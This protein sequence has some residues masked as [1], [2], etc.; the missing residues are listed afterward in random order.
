VRFLRAIPGHEGRAI[1]PILFVLP[2]VLFSLPVSA[3]DPEV[4]LNH[5]THQQWTTAEGLPQ[6]SPQ[7]IVQDDSG[8]LW[9]GTQEG[10][11]RFDGVRFRVFNRRSSPALPA[12]N[13]TAL[14]HCAGQGILAGMR[15]GGLLRILPNGR[16][17][18]LSSERDTDTLLVR[19]LLRDSRGRIWIGTRGNGLLC[20]KNVNSGFFEDIPEFSGNRILSLIESSDGSIWVGTEGHGISVISSRGQVRRLENLDST[21][22]NTIWALCEDRE[23]S[24]WAGSFGG[25]LI[26]FSSDGEVTG[27]YRQSDGLSS[28]RVISLGED[29][30]GNLW[31]GTSHGLDRIYKGRITGSSTGS[32]LEG[33]VI[34]SIL[35]DREGNLWLGTQRSGL[36]RLGDSLFSV[37]GRV[38]GHSAPMAR[39]LCESHDHRIWMGS[40]SQGLF[41]LDPEEKGGVFPKPVPGFEQMDIFALY[42]DAFG[43]LWVG[44]YEKGLFRIRGDRIDSWTTQEG[45]PVD[46]IWAMETDGDHGIW[47]GTYGGGLAHFENGVDAV[48]SSDSGLPSNLVRCLHLDA[49]GI[50]WVGLSS[51]GIVTI[52][53][54]SIVRPEGSEKLSGASVLDIHENPDGSLWLA[55]AEA[56]LCHFQSGRLSCLT[57]DN[58]LFDDKIYRILDD[59]EGQLWMSCN[60]GIFRLSEKEAR[61]C[62]SGRQTRVSCTIL[63]RPDGMPTAE[64]NGGSQPCGW[65]DH[66]G[67]LWFPTPE[68]FVSFDP[69]KT[70]AGTPDLPA[71]IESVRLGNKEIRDFSSGIQISPGAPPLEIDYTVLF[72]KNP[73]KLNFQYRLKGLHD[74]WI[75]AG[76]RRSAFFDHLPPGTFEFVLRGG[77]GEH[78][79]FVSSPLEIQ[80]LPSLRQRPIFQLGILLL[81]ILLVSIGARMRILSHKNRAHELELRISEATQ[82]LRR[83][84]RQLEEANQRLAELARKD[85]LTELANRRFFDETLSVEWERC[86]REKQ[87]LSILMIDIDYFKA[88]NDNHGHQEGDVALKAVA[89]AMKTRMRR[90]TDFIARY[91]GEEFSVIL[92]N[93]PFEAAEELARQ[94]HTDVRLA[95]IRHRASPVAE[96]VTISIGGA[97]ILPSAASTAAE[98]IGRADEA[99]YRAKESGRDRVIFSGGPTPSGGESGGE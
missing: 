97:S 69:K 59:G 19:S 66:T 82:D 1:R 11:A 5:Y 41:C 32:A 55:T 27:V 46:T 83:T 3:L 16:L 57:Y 12:N 4:P 9:I 99:L 24:V 40:S 65:R 78:W 70:L 30:R 45:L 13:V 44:T 6:S 84:G 79:G 73:G 90:A 61:A 63:G 85:P 29:A 64:C 91:G 2:L 89:G 14:Y 58:G 50:L 23:G 81:G 60:R 68:G 98:L 22:R 36:H 56:G 74:H 34:L 75:H 25:G 39:V 37:W 31:V 86:R 96:V 42:E 33:E 67:Q 94:L 49:Q 35:E 53:D 20:L 43:A 21:T 47:I 71:I 88:F 7:I 54:G 93:T 8:Y 77:I 10:L 51:G 52:D 95:G 87:W 62:A 38:P 80:V 17:K 76:P 48:I 92:G 15:G 26:R 72:L 18:R 28:D